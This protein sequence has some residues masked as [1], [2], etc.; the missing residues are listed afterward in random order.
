[1]ASGMTSLTRPAGKLAHSQ[2]RART[3]SQ[4]KS[5]APSGF[6]LDE[7]A[8]RTALFFDV[9]ERGDSS[10][11]E[12]QH[13]VAGVVDVAQKVR[14]D[15]Q[16]NASLLPNLL[17]RMDHALARDGI[18]AVGGFVEDE[19]LGAV[20]QG[21]R[22]LDEL[23]HAERVGVDLAIAHLAEADVEQCFVR[24]LQ[25]ICSGQPGELGH[26][27]D[28]SNAAHVA[29]KRVVLRHVTD[30]LADARAFL[31]CIDAEDARRAAGRSVETEQCVDER[32]LASA[33]RAEKTDGVTAQLAGQTVENGPTAQPHFEPIQFDHAHVSWLRAAPPTCSAHPGWLRG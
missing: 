14:G 5:I 28:K 4:N 30:A 32:G 29:D 24:A 8:M 33:V 6:Q 23:L 17:Q 31:P 13:F 9:A 15:Q 7:V 1:M 21:L 25:R 18:E 10:L 3:A 27:A 11:L 12:D 26:V 2:P 16:A 22:Q 20:C 19:K